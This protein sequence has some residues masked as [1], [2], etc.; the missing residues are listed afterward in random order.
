M[1]AGEGL[2]KREA[3]YTAGKNTNWYNHYEEEYE[4]SL[5]NLK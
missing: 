1:N 4:G 5:K 2:E 3:S